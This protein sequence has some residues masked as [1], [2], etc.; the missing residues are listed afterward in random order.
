MRYRLRRGHRGGKGSK[1]GQS[2][3][4]YRCV[5]VRRREPMTRVGGGVNRSEEASRPLLRM[6]V[7]YAFSL[8]LCRSWEGLSL[9]RES[10]K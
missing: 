8:N 3:W 9:G 1:L 2:A 5:R 7:S 6:V 10:Y 4:V